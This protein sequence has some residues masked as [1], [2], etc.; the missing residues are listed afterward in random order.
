MK[1]E[2]LTMDDPLYVLPFFDEF[3][4]QYS[5]EFDITNVWLCRTMGKRSRTQLVREMMGLYRPF[6]FLR[7]ASRLAYHRAAATLPKRAGA[8]R[9]FSIPQAARAYAIPCEKIG[10]PNSQ[11]FVEAMRARQ[12][13]LVL[14]VACPYIVKDALLGIP[15]LGAINIH[16]APLPRYKGMMPT[17]WQMYHGERSVGVT[18]HYMVPK[19]DEGKIL[20]QK[21]L[22]IK[23]G[24]TLDALIRRSKR[25]GAH[26]VAQVMRELRDGTAE[27]VPMDHS[28]GSYYTFPTLDEMAAFRR[29]GL[30]SI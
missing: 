25:E 9:Y 8:T 21:S 24:E 3:F 29:K 19:V 15:R 28:R 5:S 17:F 1:I 22:E 30:R 4:R 16:H 20:L 26:C 12:P 6:G 14:S 13:D 18:V 7:L 11:A 10:N 27:A 2:V 23:P